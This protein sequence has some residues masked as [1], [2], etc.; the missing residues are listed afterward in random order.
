MDVEIV[1]PEKSFQRRG[2]RGHRRLSAPVLLIDDQ[3][4]LS[5]S[6]TEALGGI[7]RPMAQ[8]IS[9]RASSISACTKSPGISAFRRSLRINRRTSREILSSL[10]RPASHS[11]ILEYKVFARS[12]DNLNISS[13]FRMRSR[14][15]YQRL[16]YSGVESGAGALLAFSMSGP[17]SIGSP[18]HII[19]VFGHT[20]NEDN[21]APN[22]SAAYLQ[23]GRRI[24]YVLSE[25]WMSSFI[26]HDDNFGSNLCI[27][28]AFVERK[29]ATYLVSLR[30]RDF[31]Y[32]PFSA[33]AWA[34]K[35][36][37]SLLP[38]VPN[39]HHPWLRRLETYV[40]AQ[41][42]ILRTVPAT[43][44]DYADHLAAIADRE[45]NRESRTA[46]FEAIRQ[47]VARRLWITEVSIPDLFSTNLRKLGELVLRADVPMA[48]SNHYGLF[49]MARL[50]G[51]YAFF[52]RLDGRKH[53]RFSLIANQIIGH[54][55]L[56]LKRP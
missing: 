38:Q 16:L 43:N 34:A 46:L 18:G 41:K 47:H 3:M 39:S 33:E 21:W 2:D 8:Q 19:P 20:F 13:K 54:T 53:P 23:I 48:T 40:S 49:V 37:Y 6:Q 5:R 26:A 36:F 51:V 56:L 32:P 14:L 24:R 4:G 42:L 9:R 10:E 29:Q 30:P 27:P 45:G 55:E 15:P 35:V 52:Q 25:A 17:K 44:V 1:G 50:P 11:E 31:Q 28:Y 12:F 7:N 22:A